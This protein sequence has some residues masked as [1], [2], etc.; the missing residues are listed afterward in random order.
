MPTDRSRSLLAVVLLGLAGLGCVEFAPDPPR[1]D[2]SGCYDLMP[3]SDER[4]VPEPPAALELTDEPYADGRSEWELDFQRFDA[5]SARR[6][7]FVYPDTA[8]GVAWW[9][10]SAEERR[11]GVGN[12]NQAAAFY[13]EGVVRG[14]RLEGE[15]LRWRYDDGGRPVEGPDSWQAPVSGRRV[16]C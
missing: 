2:I 3:G 14:E 8:L 5:R 11:F 15:L 10:E 1:R 9:W 13:I 12:K 6:A 7:F 4:R 16:G